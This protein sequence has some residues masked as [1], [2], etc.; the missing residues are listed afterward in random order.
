MNKLL[1]M[2]PLVLALLVSVNA[3]AK[4]K[5]YPNGDYYEGEWKKGQPNGIG[6]MVY[7][8]GDVY[9]GSWVFGKIEGEGKMKY[10][11]GKSYTGSWT[12]GEP[13]G[14]GIMTFND[15]KTY[16]GKWT[17]GKIL[18]GRFTDKQGY[19]FEGTF[20]D[21]VYFKQGRLSY[22]NGDFYNGEWKNNE[23][24]NGQCKLNTK[25][26][27]Y[28]GEIKNG[29]FLSGKFKG[30]IKGNFFEG[31]WKNGDFIGHC[32]LYNCNE[33]IR[34]FDGNSRVG[35]SFRGTLEY[36]NGAVY[37]GLLDENMR[38]HGQGTLKQDSLTFDGIWRNDTLLYG[39]GNL[40]RSAF[41]TY[42]LKV[43]KTGNESRTITISLGGNTIMTK[44]ALSMDMS[45]DKLVNMLT[46]MVLL[47]ERE[48]STT[49]YKKHLAGKYFFLKIPLDKYLADVF[50][51][52]IVGAEFRR[53]IDKSMVLVIGIAPISEN[54]LLFIQHPQLR[55]AESYDRGYLI[56]QT[57]FM[58][59]MSDVGIYNYTLENG[60]LRFKS[61]ADFAGGN[62]QINNDGSLRDIDFKI[63][64]PAYS[65]DQFNGL[66]ERSIRK[67]LTAVQKEAKDH[68]LSENHF[69]TNRELQEKYKTSQPD[70]APSFPG[71]KNAMMQFLRSNLQ[72]P[73]ICQ[74]NG[75]Q[76]TVVLQFTVTRDG[77]LKDIKVVREINPYLEK[78]AIRVIKLMPKWE[79]AI[80][81]GQYVDDVYTMPVS[82]KLG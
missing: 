37:S 30:E 20:E 59:N 61:V 78:E 19:V 54:K 72:Y 76:G 68:S 22:P 16:E 39:N 38:K 66:L 4:K 23:F 14:N 2:L 57:G 35:G 29:T 25:S 75:I 11:D 9:E 40:K 6:K 43:E 5:K 74:A 41:T 33:Q 34:K 44:S 79:P 17:E 52:P 45:G 70:R 63:S 47:K 51:M 77:E 55:E 64:L 62:Y 21:G 13:N 49:L 48:I 3:D 28:E 12:N 46:D 82:F 65:L 58:K 56:Q 42:N 8:N 80:S 15:G 31:N 50:K 18:S 24:V 10:K 1:F 53:M 71:G 32:I 69:M 60:N 26:L 67:N 7:A 73:S 36:K 27:Q 81:G